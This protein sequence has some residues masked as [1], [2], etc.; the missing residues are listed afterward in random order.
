MRKT[1]DDC[2]VDIED[3]VAKVSFKDDEKSKETIENIIFMEFMVDEGDTVKEGDTLLSV[4]VMKGKLE[5]Q[6][7]VRG[8][9][10]ELNQAVAESPERLQQDPTEWLV[11][12]EQE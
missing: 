8:K 9:V 1:Y 5:L 4:E 12:I 2:Y 3:D 6:S 7:R 10:I 11:R